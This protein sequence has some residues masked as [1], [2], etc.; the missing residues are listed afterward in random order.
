M[1]K[2][3]KT[4]AVL[5][6]PSKTVAAFRVGTTNHGENSDGGELRPAKDIAWQIFV[7]CQV[8]EHVNSTSSFLTIYCRLTSR[9]YTRLT[10]RVLYLRR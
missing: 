6:L 1:T 8:T 2:R 5:F 10:N 4:N 9:Y 3:K 7:F